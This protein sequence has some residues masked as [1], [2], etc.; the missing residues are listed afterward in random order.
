MVRVIESHDVAVDGEKVTKY[1]EYSGLSTDE[2]PAGPISTGSVFIEVD[3]GDAYMFD[4]ETENWIKV[5]D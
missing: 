5:G 2:K 4:E 1:V 3:T